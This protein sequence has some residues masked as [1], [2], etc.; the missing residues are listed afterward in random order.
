M[1]WM[2]KKMQNNIGYEGNEYF[3]SPYITVLLIKDHS[4]R[5]LGIKPFYYIFT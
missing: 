2:Q 5:N 3:K 1:H 4:K